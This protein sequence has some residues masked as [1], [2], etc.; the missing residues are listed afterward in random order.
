MSES[1]VATT[2]RMVPIGTQ[3]VSRVVARN[4]AGDMMCSEGSVGVVI[5]APLEPS[6]AYRVR[7]VDGNEAELRRAEFSVR[8]RHQKH[9]LERLGAFVDGI[10]L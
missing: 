8:K 2:H 10:D 9:G 3:V 4:A 7:F 6:D 1:A 5:G